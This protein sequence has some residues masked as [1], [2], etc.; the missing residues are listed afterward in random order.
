MLRA[1]NKRVQQRSDG[2]A[3]TAAFN[4]WRDRPASRRTNRGERPA[5]VS[6]P[7]PWNTVWK[8][9]HSLTKPAGGGMA[10]RLVAA[11]RAPT[12]NTQELRRARL[13]GRWRN[14]QLND[15][16]HR[17]PTIFPVGERM[18]CKVQERNRPPDI[19]G[20]FWLPY[21]SLSIF[22]LLSSPRRKVFGRAGLVTLFS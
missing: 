17:R 14:C 21:V 8:T 9:Y 3:L 7:K 19:T 10:A 16:H 2:R 20:G 13:C 4:R 1:R 11:N 5:S 18:F 12:P 15:R 22:S 6:S